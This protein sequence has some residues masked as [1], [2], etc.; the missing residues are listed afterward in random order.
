[1]GGYRNS[2]VC[3]S[4]AAGNGAARA[5]ATP[6]MAIADAIFCRVSAFTAFNGTARGMVGGVVGTKASTKIATIM[7]RK[8]SDLFIIVQSFFR[9]DN[10]WKRIET[11]VQATAAPALCLS[12]DI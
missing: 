10:A 6:N 5:S 8:A 2:L 7:A 9:L 11:T 3:P 4:A 12:K 1:M